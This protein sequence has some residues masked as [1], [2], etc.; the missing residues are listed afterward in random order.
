MFLIN[1]STISLFCLVTQIYSFLS[2]SLAWIPKLQHL[3]TTSSTQKL[4][5]NLGSMDERTKILKILKF[6]PSFPHVFKNL[7]KRT[8]NCCRKLIQKMFQLFFMAQ[9]HLHLPF[10]NTLIASL[11]TLD[12][13]RLASWLHM[14]TSID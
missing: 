8:R 13:A 7:L 3:K 6:F 5:L 2:C 11:N 10:N 12:A 4:T 1:A 9:E 14:Y